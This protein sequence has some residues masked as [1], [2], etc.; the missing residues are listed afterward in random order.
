MSRLRVVRYSR[1]RKVVEHCGYVWLRTDGSHNS[2]RAPEGDTIVY[3]G[4]GS[5]VPGRGLTRDIVRDLRLSVDEY[6]RLLDEI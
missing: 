5:R 6:N 1:L 4:S 3:S 2:F